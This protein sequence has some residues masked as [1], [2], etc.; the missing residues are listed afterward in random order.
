MNYT[1]YN[2]DTGVL[3]SNA[4]MPEE[5][6]EQS[7]LS[8]VEGHY[9]IQ[10]EYYDIATET[11]KPRIELTGTSIN[12][13]TFNQGDTVIISGLPIPCTLNVRGF[14]MVDVDDG[15]LEI[16]TTDAAGEYAVI[17]KQMPYLTKKFIYEVL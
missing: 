1:R 9:D 5:M 11:V 16:D 13:T 8:Y 17:F 2:P 4:V 10:T 7:T 12:G 15:S 6:R 14:G 3:L